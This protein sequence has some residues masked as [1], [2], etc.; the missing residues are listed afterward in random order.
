M[1]IFTFSYYFAHFQHLASFA[2][3]TFLIKDLLNVLLVLVWLTLTFTRPLLIVAFSDSFADFSFCSACFNFNSSDNQFSFNLNKNV[4][5]VSRFGT[6]YSVNVLLLF[7]RCFP[8]DY[9][10]ALGSFFLQ[11]GHA[12]WRRV[13]S[14]VSPQFWGHGSW[15]EGGRK[16]VETEPPPACR[17]EP[18][19]LTWRTEDFISWK[20]NEPGEHWE[21]SCVLPEMM[22]ASC[23]TCTYNQSL[24]LL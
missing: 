14:C 6:V 21:A 23:S 24:L 10:S 22:A 20:P 15:A 12:E 2:I 5:L 16:R 3:L 1:L 9:C 18:G 19:C 11:W 8:R 17:Q 7:V 4:C 13:P